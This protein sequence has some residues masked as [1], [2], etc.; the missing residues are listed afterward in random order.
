[1]DS[2]ISSQT[3]LPARLWFIAPHKTTGPTIQIEETTD[4]R[5][6]RLCLR[7]GKDMVYST[8]CCCGVWWCVQRALRDLH[9]VQ[10][11]WVGTAGELRK[12]RIV[13]V[14]LVSSRLPRT[15]AYGGNEGVRRVRGVS[16]EARSRNLRVPSGQSL[17]LGV[18]DRPVSGLHR[19]AQR[20]HQRLENYRPSVFT[21]FA[22]TFQQTTME[23][24]IATA[25]V[26]VAL[27]WPLLNP[28]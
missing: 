2:I 13:G 23:R 17:R 26:S 8:C 12:R 11:N 4:P 16:H 5:A 20:H 10:R 25:H 21:T 28:R 3:A 14:Q 15:L 9:F 6:A 18:G 1:M 22:Y 24:K 27:Q 19:Q 7:S